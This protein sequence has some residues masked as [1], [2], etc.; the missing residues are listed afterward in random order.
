M[1]PAKGNNARGFWESSRVVKLNG[2]ILSSAGLAWDAPVPF[3]QS[4]FSSQLREGFENDAREIVEQE[5]GDS[6]L[7]VLKDPRICLLLPFWIDV[8]HQ[9][10]IQPT[11]LHPIRHPLEVAQSLERR[12]GIPISRGL[13]L[14]LRYN[15]AAENGS[16]RYPRCF[17]RFSDLLQDWRGTLGRLNTELGKPLPDNSTTAASQVEQFLTTDLMHHHASPDDIHS[18]HIPDWVRKTYLA[19]HHLGKGEPSQQ[20]TRQLNDAR[21]RLDE[22]DQAM[23]PVILD[24]TEESA[25]RGQHIEDLVR[26][27]QANGKIIEAERLET[28]ALRDELLAV[29]RENETHKSE[30]V[31]L[32]NELGTLRTD[33]NHQLAARDQI[34]ETLTNRDEHQSKSLAEVQRRVS[35]LE[36]RLSLAAQS[37]QRLMA[38]R[39]WRSSNLVG[40]LGQRLL[41]QKSPEDPV[42]NL[43]RLLGAFGTANAVYPRLNWFRRRAITKIIERSGLF[44]ESYYLSQCT[45]PTAK[46][47]NRPLLHYLNQPLESTANPHPLFDT[48]FYL[49]RNPDVA[50]AGTNPLQHF[51][52]YGAWEHR[53]PHPWF[54]VTYYLHENPDIAQSKANPLHHYLVHGASEGRNPHPGFDTKHYL[55]A[56]PDVAQS[57]INPLV[58]FVLH[59]L[60]EGKCPR[61]Q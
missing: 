6:P 37:V 15:L 24:I 26:Q 7:F 50:E 38:S 44:D 40:R 21:K 35:E 18:N 33:L 57:R 59:G 49:E 3:P 14:W 27:Q 45:D 23:T 17:L 60:K 12:D 42:E 9:T 36:R 22:A 2:R 5:F 16:R 58:H 1:P 53:D 51:V 19:L 28:K 25:S 54:S 47:N 61:P 20:V 39:W 4:W 11:F 46:G 41:L 32:H 55:A 34:I 30:I 48:A 29:R 31:T 52:E 43:S 8:L 10:G 13:L 56:N